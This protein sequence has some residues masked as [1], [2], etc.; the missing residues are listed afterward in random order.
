EYI[1]GFYNTTRIHSHCEYE[2]PQNFEKQYLK[3]K[4]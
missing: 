2:S 4:H 1:E 3:H